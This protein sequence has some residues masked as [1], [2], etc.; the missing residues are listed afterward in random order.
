MTTS[1]LERSAK[2]RYD[3]A[4]R[5]ARRRVV[6]WIIVVVAILIVIAATGNMH[7]GKHHPE[8]VNALSVIWALIVWGM[9]VGALVALFRRY[10]R[11]RAHREL[12]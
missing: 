6:G 12:R 9:I 1:Y 2:R 10:R 7:S 3:V 4:V 8:W 11:R 5:S